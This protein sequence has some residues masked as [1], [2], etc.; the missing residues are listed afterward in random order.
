LKEKLLAAHRGGISTVIIPYDNARDLKEIP[1]KIKNDLEIFPVKVIDE[2]LEIALETSP[3]PLSE[4][5]YNRV[6]GTENAHKNDLRPS[7]H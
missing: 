1:D 6:S 5:D 2:V 4:E 7:T 3:K